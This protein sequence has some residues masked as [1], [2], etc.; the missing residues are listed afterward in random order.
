MKTYYFYK[1]ESGMTGPFALTTDNVLKYVPR[2]FGIY[3]LS[4]PDSNGAGP[5]VCYVGRSADIEGRLLQH[6]GTGYPNFYYREV[7]GGEEGA[8]RAECTEYHRYGQTDHLDNELHPAK[9]SVYS[10][11]PV[12]GA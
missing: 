1:P 9:P 5:L 10:R 8:Y 11:C 12:C 2:S 4:H 3:F 7:Q 6:V